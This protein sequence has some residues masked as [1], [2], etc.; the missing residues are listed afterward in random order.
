[1]IEPQERAVKLLP[2]VVPFLL[3]G[4]ASSGVLPLGPD[5]FIIS[6]DTAKLGGGVSAAAAAEVVEEANEFC[7]S[8]GKKVETVDLQLEPGR[9][10]SMG[11]V[12][13]QFKCV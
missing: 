11:S 1:M 7:V 12:T 2:L 13:L 9:L 6:K 8:R 10:G 3:L 4:C 5:K